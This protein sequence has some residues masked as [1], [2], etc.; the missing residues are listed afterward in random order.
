VAVHG[1]KWLAQALPYQRKLWALE[2]LFIP[3]IQL[4][5]SCP[6]I[7]FKLHRRRFP[8]KIAL[9]VAIR[10]AQ[11]QTLKRDRVYPLSTVISMA[12]YYRIFRYIT[13]T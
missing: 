9:A 6:N 13:R 5:L 11:V 10:K 2:K 1:R 4:R 3:R 7:P 12:S 8:T